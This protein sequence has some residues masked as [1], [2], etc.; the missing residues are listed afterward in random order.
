MP[1]SKT[2]P[3]VAK[4][5]GD[6]HA[7]LFRTARYAEL[8][9]RIDADL[10]HAPASVTPASL[11]LRA[12]VDIL[13]R[14]PAKALA[15]LTKHA[16]RFT[17]AQECAEVAIREGTAYGRLGDEAAANA[18]FKKAKELA[19][20]NSQLETL[21]LVQRAG[22]A[23]IARKLDVAE[24]FA[25]SAL[26]TATGDVGLEAR[27]I[28]GASAASRG[29]VAEQG[30]I[31]LE[32]RNVSRKDP[33]AATWLRA[34][35]AS[36]IA[37][38]ARELPSPALRDAAYADA[39][40]IPWTP[41]TGEQRFTMLR[42]VAWRYAL[43]GDAFNAFRNLKR[44]SEI[45]PSDGWRVMSSC[46]R[47]YLADVL[48][49]PRWA[50]QELADAHELAA[51]VAWNALDGEERFAL[52]LLAERF[53]SRDPALALAYVAR[54][55]EAGKH[56][57]RSLVSNE[58]RRVD[59]ME[60]YSFGSVQRALGEDAEAARLLKRA[61]K[62]YDSIGYEWRAARAALELAAVTGDER[63]KE[64][65]TERLAA[66]PQSW[67]ARGSARPKRPEPSEA[68]LLTPAQRAVYDL[69][70]LGRST[71]EIANEQGRSEF[72]IRNHIKA[73]LKTF[74]LSSRTALLAKANAA[75]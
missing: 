9:E 36:Q 4:A 30:A 22:T 65:A 47:A 31:L 73:I 1:K 49:E 69:L 10:A 14:E 52:S 3:A 19:G 72:T 59:A 57:S 50:E 44:A 68:A 58:D 15:F 12:R 64:R 48:G 16:S 53:A 27:I 42:A 6:S 46:D 5:P 28:L 34:L 2:N 21:L 37:Y 20:G 33:A 41:D 25:A 40:E 60:A 62:T 43:D 32:A 63:W 45:A 54:Y 66:Y 71:S 8:V 26:E 61:Y 11:I 7:E 74:A 18:K 70:L 23:W 51:R 24:K 38:L 35:I 13:R 55:K 56:F 29:N 17:R 39:A 75:T 67:L